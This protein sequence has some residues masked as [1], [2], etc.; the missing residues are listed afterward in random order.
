MLPPSG[1][2]GSLNIR[3]GFNITS[4]SSPGACPVELPSKFHFGNVSMDDAYLL[5][6]GLVWGR[7]FIMKYQKEWDADEICETRY[8]GKVIV[9]VIV[10]HNNISYLTLPTG[11]VRVLL[12]VLPTASTHTYSANTVSVGIGRS[13]YF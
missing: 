11:S 3:H 12:R 6:V 10:V 13:M 2:N 1:R 4:E 7:G 9:I 5:F 8:I